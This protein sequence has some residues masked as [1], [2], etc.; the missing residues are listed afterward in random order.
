MEMSSAAALHSHSNVVGLECAFGRIVLESVEEV[1]LLHRLQPDIVPERVDSAHG[2]HCLYAARVRVVREEQLLGPVKVSST[3]QR[4]LG[5]I[6]PL[7][8]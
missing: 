6:K 5:P 8:P 1:L 2:L 3:T 7:E 4:F